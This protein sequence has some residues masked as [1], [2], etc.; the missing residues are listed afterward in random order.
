MDKYERLRHFAAINWPQ[1]AVS[2]TGEGSVSGKP[3][4]INQ[5][6]NPNRGLDLGPCF[7][8][9]EPDTT[10]SRI[11]YHGPTV[12]PWV[13]PFIRSTSEMHLCVLLNTKY[14]PNNRTHVHRVPLSQKSAH[15]VWTLSK[16]PRETSCTV[17]IKTLK[18]IHVRNLYLG[19]GSVSACVCVCVCKCI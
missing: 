14:T 3:V 15:N 8:R 16:Q 2:L 9:H 4:S 12:L 11:R 18:K 17:I 1:L 13:L 19:T 5:T 6:E 7:L 10:K